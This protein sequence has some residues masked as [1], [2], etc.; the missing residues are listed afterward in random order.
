MSAIPAVPVQQINPSPALVQNVV[1]GSYP[2]Q[3]AAAAPRYAVY[4][5]PAD[6]RLRPWIL[7]GSVLLG[8]CELC[9][10]LTHPQNTYSTSVYGSSYD[11]LHLRWW[12]KYWHTLG[13]FRG[14]LYIRRSSSTWVL[15]RM[16][17]SPCRQGFGNKLSSLSF[18]KHSTNTSNSFSGPFLVLG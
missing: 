2:M 8:V 16:D 10:F 12:R 5:K 4:D 13:S 11:H 14:W 9:I 7:L 17:P 3:A 1:P 15:H 18:I 6:R